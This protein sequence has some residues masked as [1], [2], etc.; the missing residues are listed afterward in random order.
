MYDFVYSVEKF[1]GVVEHILA[2]LDKAVDFF[3]INFTFGEAD[4]GFD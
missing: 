3:D 1:N 2:A 4:G